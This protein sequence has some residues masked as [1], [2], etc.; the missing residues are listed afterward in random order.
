V[1]GARL[2]LPNSALRTQAGPPRNFDNLNGHPPDGAVAVHELLRNLDS[3]A[4]V[5]AHVAEVLVCLGAVSRGTVRATRRANFC[6][7][8]LMGRSSISRRRAPVTSL[9]GAAET[10]I[11]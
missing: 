1:D 8:Y 5:L 9:I 7:P 3:E 11:L 10:S 2:E 6:R 4:V